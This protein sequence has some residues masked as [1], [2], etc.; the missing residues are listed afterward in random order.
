MAGFSTITGNESIVFADNASFDGTERG[1]RMTAN[2]QLW[3]GSASSPY[4]RTATLTS[5][6]GSLTITNGP[7]S[8]DF[9]VTG[10]SLPA[11]GATG[12]ILRSDGTNWVA[13]TSTYPNTNAVSTLLYASAANVLSALS[14]A[15]NGLLVTSATGVPSVLAGPGATGRVLQSNAAAAPSFSTASFPSTATGTGTILRADGTN[16]VATTSTYPNTNAVSTLL[17]ASSANV[18]A[19]LAT[20][21][22]GLLVTGNT[23]IPSVL[24]GPGATGRILQSNSALAPSFSTATYPSVG[25][26]T[27]SFL[28]AD[29]TNWVASTATIPTTFAQGDLILASTANTLTA[30]T[31]DTGS[32]RYLSNTGTNNNA[33]WAQIALT[34][35]ITG[36]L[37]IANGGTNAS[38]MATSLGIV[39]YDGT[40]LVTSSTATLDA[41]NRYVN[42][43]QPS[44]L[45]SVHTSSLSNVTGDG[46]EYTV[47]FNNSNY[48]Q[49][50][51]YNSGTGI[52]TCPVTG[53]YLFTA[54]LSLEGVLAAHTSSV[55]RIQVGG[56]P[57]IFIQNAF[58]SATPTG[59]TT[60]RATQIMNCSAND[61]VTVR[62]T[63]SNGT[64]VVDIKAE[65]SGE[66]STFSGCLLC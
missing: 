47:L 16:W 38:S 18:M 48:D 9:A 44:F 12:T 37:P 14:T 31:K 17:Y 32:T 1:G 53:K 49:G 34:T 6:G 66:Y 20:A 27:G 60:V 13:T 10:G 2:G 7:G 29:G 30:L 52:Y 42:T 65:S 22:N 21:N 56:T 58:T 45:V 15:N 61:Q 33:S 8:I 35:G 4:V 40:R 41:S 43:S 3:I 54:A 24:A 55:I 19:A 51:G 26:S 50:S 64:K 25:T 63:V 28:R 11:A 23:G 39:K 36:I 5:A 57:F 59:E 62:L 46:T